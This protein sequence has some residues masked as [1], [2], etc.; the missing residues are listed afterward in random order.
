MTSDRSAKAAS[1]FLATQFLTLTAIA[2]KHCDQ[3]GK[4]VLTRQNRRRRATQARTSTGGQRQLP[5][6]QTNEQK[7]A[8]V[9]EKDEFKL[10]DLGELLFPSCC[11]LRVQSLAAGY[12]R[13]LGGGPPQLFL[14]GA[15]GGNC[16]KSSMIPGDF[17]V[18]ISLR[19][20][21]FL[22]RLRP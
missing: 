14:T 20:M 6:L 5:L 4:T 7:I 8:E 13:P 3:A 10:C 2:F 12:Y 21:N 19:E 22:S 18:A 15:S 11:R 1:A 16:G 9:A 17:I